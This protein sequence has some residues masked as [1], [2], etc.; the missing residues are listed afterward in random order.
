MLASN[1]ERTGRG[2]RAVVVFSAPAVIFFPGEDGKTGEA[3][4]KKPEEL[5]ETLKLKGLTW[6]NKLIREVATEE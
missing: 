6:W 4:F 1:Q 2:K 5:E 3:V